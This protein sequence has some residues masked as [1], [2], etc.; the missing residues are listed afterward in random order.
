[1][2]MALSNYK[3][4]SRFPDTRSADDRTNDVGEFHA[5]TCRQTTV[6]ATGV[7]RHC[8][9]EGAGVGHQDE[10]APTRKT[11]RSPVS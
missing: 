8:S 6:V 9:R 1:M 4:G 7:T 10:Q 11:D 3:V 5:A 2:T